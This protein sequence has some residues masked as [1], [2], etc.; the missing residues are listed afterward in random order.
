MR[1][2]LKNYLQ[3]TYSF[4]QKGNTTL[5]DI[6]FQIFLKLKV[7]FM[8]AKIISSQLQIGIEREKKIKL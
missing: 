6:Q 1:F 5:T 4:S 2:I 7:I 3:L 8:Q